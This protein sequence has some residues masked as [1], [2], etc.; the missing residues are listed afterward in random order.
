MGL[1][2]SLCSA[3]VIHYL[4][5]CIL[6]SRRD[7]KWSDKYL[8]AFHLYH[9]F[10]LRSLKMPMIPNL[11]WDQIMYFTQVLRDS[12]PSLTGDTLTHPAPH[13]LAAALLLH[14]QLFE[15]ELWKE[16]C[17]QNKAC[18]AWFPCEFNSQQL[19][20]F[21]KTHKATGTPRTCN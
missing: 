1:L 11:L 20:G 13:S 4:C 12:I 6:T 17:F 18:P 8:V 5:I 3:P 14:S 7:L 9:Q 16:I 15:G 19:A 2:S 21:W 10:Q